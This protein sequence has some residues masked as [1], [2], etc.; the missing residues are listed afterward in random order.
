MARRG[1]G[2]PRSRGGALSWACLGAG[3]LPC[4]PCPRGARS[5]W[6]NHPSPGSGLGCP[7]LSSAAS[8]ATRPPSWTSLSPREA[9]R[10][11]GPAWEL[12][13]STVVWSGRRAPPWAAGRRARPPVSASESPGWAVD[14]DLGSARGRGRVWTLQ[15]KEISVCLPLVQTLPVVSESTLNTFQALWPEIQRLQHLATICCSG[16]FSRISFTNS[17]NKKYLSNINHCAGQIE[18]TKVEERAWSL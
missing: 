2:S 1:P 16:L 13:L 9:T 6:P 7:L 12:C 4:G 15:R 14:L 8:R 3:L 17:F 18:D 11:L 10:P 5:A